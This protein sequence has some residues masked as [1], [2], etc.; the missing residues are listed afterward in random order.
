ML[1]HQIHITSIN[2]VIFLQ[3]KQTNKNGKTLPRLA[4]LPIYIE[5]G[6]VTSW[7]Q[8]LNTP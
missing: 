4:F 5:F 6:L 3:Y 7:R 1:K 2:S 8:I